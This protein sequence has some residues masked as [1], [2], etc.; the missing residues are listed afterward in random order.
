MSESKKGDK[1]M[2][3]GRLLISIS[4]VFLVICTTPFVQ[5][6]PA[7]LDTSDAYWWWGDPAGTSR[8][9]RTD[10]GI[11]GN[12]KV[13][14]SSDSGSAKGLAISL[15]LVVFNNPSACA[16]PN[17]CLD[18]DF[19]NP[20]VMIDVVYAGG[21][22]VGASEWTNIGFHYKAGE[23]EGSIA[24]LFGLFLNAEDEGFGLLNPRG[25]EV[26]YVIRLHGPVN[27]AAMPAHVQ[28]YGGGCVDFAPY[29]YGFP[30]GSNNLYLGLGQCQDVIFAVNPP[31]P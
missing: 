6:A 22:I 2:K 1:T 21:N 28:S 9:V 30:T 20:D 26:H 16:V 7:E 24:D 18:P 27:P 31:P 13:H 8:I 25:A 23:N 17:M 5:A 4:A 15:W 11:S 29:G 3:A 14:L 10:K 19:A 12:I